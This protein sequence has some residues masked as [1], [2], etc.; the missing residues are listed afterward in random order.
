MELKSLVTIH[1]KR[2]LTTRLYN[3]SRN[4]KFADSSILLQKVINYLVKC[5]S[6]G[7]AQNKGNA[8]AIQPTINSI[9]PHTFGDHKNSDNKWCKFKQDPASCKHHDL[10]YGKDLFGDELRSA[11]E[12]IFSDYCTDAVADKLAP[13]TN[14]QKNEALNSVVDSKN[15]KIRCYGGSESNDFRVVCGVAQTN[16]RY[17]Y[18]S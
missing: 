6:Y 12:N 4:T 1:L 16:L 3:L 14:S 17:G 9:V 2:S 13:M 11:L 18:V 5:F 10:L 15:P 7:V 8:K